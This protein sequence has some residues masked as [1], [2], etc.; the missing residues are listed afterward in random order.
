LATSKSIEE[1]GRGIARLLIAKPFEVPA[2]ISGFLLLFFL[3]FALHLPNKIQIGDCDRF[4]PLTFSRHL[5]TQV[6]L[7]VKS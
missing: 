6:S 3:L 5:L 7:W 1:R 2:V 4:R